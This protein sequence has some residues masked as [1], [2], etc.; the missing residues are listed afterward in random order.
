[1]I[2][3]HINNIGWEIKIK[4]IGIKIRICYHFDNIIYIDNFNLKKIKVYQN[5]YQDL[6]IYKM[7]MNH[8]MVEDPCILLLTYL[9][10]NISYFC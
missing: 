8:K 2:N 9:L 3:C 5:D 7:C 10:S 1:M 4:Q 6:L